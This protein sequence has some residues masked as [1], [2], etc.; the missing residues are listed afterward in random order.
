MI[1][2][3]YESAIALRLN[4]KGKGEKHLFDFIPFPNLYGEVYSLI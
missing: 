4:A 3:W 1:A 2:T